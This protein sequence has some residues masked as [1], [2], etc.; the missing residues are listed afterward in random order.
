MGTLRNERY[1]RLQVCGEPWTS[2]RQV[3]VVDVPTVADGF[4][5]EPISAPVPAED[6][7]VV[8]RAELVG[9][10]SGQRFEPM[11]GPLGRFVDPVQYAV[12][13][14]QVEVFQVIKPPV[15]STQPASCVTSSPS[16]ARTSSASW[17]SPRAIC[18][19][20][21]AGSSSISSESVT[22][23]CTQ[24]RNAS[25]IASDL[26]EYPRRSHSSSMRARRD[27]GTRTV[28]FPSRSSPGSVSALVGCDTGGPREE[29]SSTV[30][31]A[32]HEPR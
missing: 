11:V 10:I 22:G 14:L 19:R 18:S 32:R 29:L 16:R 20:L 28:I 1:E 27:S 6:G 8:S 26:L 9:R 5:T 17:V 15:W 3:T 13:D 21:S 31:S 12:G 2:G 4:D 30:S 7:S 24:S 23:G 25:L